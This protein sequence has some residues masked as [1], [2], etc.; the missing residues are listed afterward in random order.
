MKKVLTDHGHIL[1]WMGAHHLFP[2]QGADGALGFAAHGALE[3]RTPIGWQHF[4]PALRA[5][6]A[7]VLVDEEA[8]TA[9]VV[10][11]EE[12]ARA[13]T[14]EAEHKANL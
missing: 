1:H 3:G 9:E 5:K 12:A 7:A 4:F 6:N 10:S 11:Q 14:P 8:G 2:V 13:G